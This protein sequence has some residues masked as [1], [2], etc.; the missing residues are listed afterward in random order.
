MW[1]A[2]TFRAYD[3]VEQPLDAAAAEAL[4]QAQL[5]KALEEAREEALGQGEILTTRC[6]TTQEGDR[7]FV[8]LTA[9]C[10]EDIA[11]EVPM[12]ADEIAQ[13]RAASE[14]PPTEEKPAKE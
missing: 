6:E 3:P 12:T 8:T 14:P 1:E 7:L 11:K 5:R 4:L 13:I 10:F 9:H 2:E